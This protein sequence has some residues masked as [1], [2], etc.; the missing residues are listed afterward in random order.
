MNKLLM[1]YG[2]VLLS[3]PTVAS[4]QQSTKEPVLQTKT[5]TVSTFENNITALTINAEVNKGT[6]SLYKMANEG[7][8]ELNLDE[9]EYVEEDTDI[10]LGFNTADYLPEGFDPYETY[11]DLNSIIYVENEVESDLGI[12]TE[13]YLPEGF[14]P[15][16]EVLDVHGINF[17]EDEDMELGF[18]T[19][20]YLP[21]GFSPYEAYVDLD[22]IKYVEEEV[23]L[24]L[25]LGSDY[26]LPEGFDPYSDVLE[27]ASINYVEVEDIDLGFDTAQ[28]LPQDFD[29]YLG[30][31]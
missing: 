20:D 3:S 12:P 24:E 25:N 4:D 13:D 11:F 28:Y 1:I 10:D 8:Y 2:C 27:V 9:I 22:S 5:E 31:N 14:D 7:Y 26:T 23:A 30:S 15:Y 18:N 21:E 17:V 29:P 16:T 6:S 19:A